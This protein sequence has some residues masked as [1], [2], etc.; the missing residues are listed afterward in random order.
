MPVLK[1]IKVDEFEN[2]TVVVVKDIQLRTK[3]A[4]DGHL[5]IAV[6]E[7]NKTD[8]ATPDETFNSQ[9]AQISALT[10]LEVLFDFPSEKSLSKFI[11]YLTEIKKEV[12]G[13]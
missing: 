2:V 9:P 10:E 13:K 4:K 5:H 8:Q 1:G 7:V 6:A 12:Y 3:K 11:Q